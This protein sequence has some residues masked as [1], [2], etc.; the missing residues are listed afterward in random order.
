MTEQEHDP[1]V[2]ERYRELGR[3]EPGAE[4]DAAILAAS[5]WAVEARPAPLVAPAGR[6]RWYVPLAAAAVIVLS[7]AVVF[8]I[9]YE[10]PEM[11]GGAP[12]P[13][14]SDERARDEAP[15]APPPEPR[16]GAPVG[17]DAARQAAPELQVVA[18]EAKREAP[19]AEPA[20]K[21]PV[22]AAPAARP[23]PM[24]EQKA[25]GR[26]AERSAAEESALEDSS[27]R[28]LERIAELRRQG[29]DEE[30]DRQLE[31]FKKRYPDYKVPESALRRQ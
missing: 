25:L 2:S 8:R 31:K 12:A 3:E 10:A 11:D 21:A 13:A 14:V 9:W 24:M 1:K 16:K 22:A 18:P 7:T 30:A 19:A 28:W 5:R 17:K 20:A 29:K 15:A 27:E 23:A 6:R 4:L 26:L